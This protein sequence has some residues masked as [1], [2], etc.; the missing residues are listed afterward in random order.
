MKHHWLHWWVRTFVLVNEN[1]RIK[2]FGKE[3]KPLQE[4]YVADWYAKTSDYYL[5]PLKEIHLHSSSII[6][7]FDTDISIILIYIFCSAGILILIISCINYINLSTANFEA[8]KKSVAIKKIIGAGRSYLFKQYMSFS[9]ML[10]FLCIFAA[11]IISSYSIPILK[12][13][14][15]LGIDIPYSKP[16][17]WLIVVCF[18]LTTG[19]LSGLYPSSYICKTVTTANPKAQISRTIFKNGLITIQFSITIL[20]LIAVVTIKKQM[21]ESIKGNLGYN[22]SSLIS[23][24]STESIYNHCKVMQ[25]EINNIPG[26]IAITSCGF[27]L[28]GYIGNYWPAKP[29]GAEKIDIYHTSVASNFF[30]LLGIPLK[31]KLGELREDTSAASDIA[32]INEEAVKQF[33]IGETVVGKI[34]NLGNTKISIAGIAGDFHIG[35]MR[36]L[37]KPI[38]F[39]ISDKNWNQIVKIE[40]AKQANVIGNIQKVWEKFETEEPFTYQFIDDLIGEQYNKEKSLFKLFNVFSA[41]AMIISLIGLFGLVQLLLRFRIKEIGIRKVHGAG[42]FQVMSLLNKD[43]IKWVVIAFIIACPI[44]W[45]VMHEWLQ[46]FAYKTELS[47]WVFMLVGTIAIVIALFTVSLQSWWAATRNPVEALRYE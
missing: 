20:L 41:L 11:I 24:S 25:N 47:W 13:Q 27:K 12:M 22:H 5:Q 38:Q 1:S 17:F 26:V 10:T 36:E 8:R 23:F 32:I 34:Y 46:N 31:Q 28:P 37:I 45:Y 6:G 29:Q 19:I 3:M 43:F 40:K 33:G 9:V 42:V 7:S 16:V 44:A 15:I 2:D 14:G 30:D 35:S 21:N 4:K 39:T 18:G